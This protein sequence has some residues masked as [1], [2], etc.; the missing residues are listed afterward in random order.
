MRIS[1][2]DASMFYYLLNGIFLIVPSIFVFSLNPSSFSKHYFMQGFWGSIASTV[3]CT[4]VDYAL[5]MKDA[6]KGPVVA[7]LNTRIV[8]VLIIDALIAKSVLTAMQWIGLLF[9]IIGT[10]ILCIPD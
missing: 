6:P 4:F 5:G 9:G 7:L 3:A 8:L 1:L 2:V 10:L